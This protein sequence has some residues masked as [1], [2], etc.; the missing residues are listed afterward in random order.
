MER[1]HSV[2]MKQLPRGMRGLLPREFVLQNWRRRL[3]AA[4]ID[5]V[6]EDGYHQA[7]I[8]QITSR[9]H[10][11]RGDFYECFESRDE[12]FLAA[13]EEAVERMREVVLV[14]CAREDDWGQGVC[15]A[16]AALLARMSSEPAEADLVFVEGLNA[17]R[18]FHDRYEEAVR[19]FAPY[20][21]DRAPAVAGG[22]QLPEGTAE[23]VVGS[24]ASLL[25]RRI[26]AGEGKHLEQFFP[27]IAE[28]ALTPYVGS[29]KARRIISAA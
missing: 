2:L 23:A 5:C 26:L 22:G 8:G 28:F 12:V 18:D 19:S 17:G 11:A 9:A 14:A 13:Y 15:A 27:E 1:S 6:H 4:A 3:I 25:G 29:K 21:R 20:L 7:S 10:V 24:I 16:I